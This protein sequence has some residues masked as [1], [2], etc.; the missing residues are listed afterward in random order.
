MLNQMVCQ[1]GTKTLQTKFNEVKKLYEHQ[2][3]YT[4]I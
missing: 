2:A 4:F 3:N 1:R